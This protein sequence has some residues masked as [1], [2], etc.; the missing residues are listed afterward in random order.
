MLIEEGCLNCGK[1]KMI[2]LHLCKECIIVKE[3]SYAESAKLNENFSQ[4][5]LRRE[6]VLKLERKN[7]I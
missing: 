2:Y 3:K 5:I 7:A 4:V 1:P 6:N